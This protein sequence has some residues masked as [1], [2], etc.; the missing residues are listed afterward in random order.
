MEL[1]TTIA[2][3]Q[4]AASHLI[5][6]DEMLAACEQIWLEGNSNILG[7]SGIL[8]EGWGMVVM[9][10]APCHSLARRCVAK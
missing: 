7:A 8:A 1:R 2:V 6:S 9:L 10:T 4:G 3:T 5:S